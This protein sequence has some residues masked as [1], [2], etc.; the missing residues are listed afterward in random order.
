MKAQHLWFRILEANGARARL[1][2]TARLDRVDR[3]KQDTAGETELARSSLGGIA[4]EEAVVCV[5]QYQVVGYSCGF[6]WIREKTRVAAS[7]VVVVRSSGRLVLGQTTL[8][9]LR[10]KR[11]LPTC[12]TRITAT[13]SPISRRLASRPEA[14]VDLGDEVSAEKRLDMYEQQQGEDLQFYNVSMDIQGTLGLANLPFCFVQ[15][16]CKSGQ[17]GLGVIFWGE[18]RGSSGRPAYSEACVSWQRKS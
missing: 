9:R 10:W 6:S 3:V 12:S 8:R 4:G 17:N 7:P 5:V 2:G 18:R 1:G 11:A 15:P 13:G 16:S 14:D